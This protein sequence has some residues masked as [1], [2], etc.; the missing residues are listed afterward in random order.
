MHIAV[1]FQ[2]EGDANP[3]AVTEVEG[4]ITDMLL[5]TP[6]DTVSHINLEGKRF[7]GEV[8]RRH[9]DF[10]LEDGLDISG[11]VTVTLTLKRMPERR[12]H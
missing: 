5:P 7:E 10:S 12:V 9:F 4:Q 1:V 2:F 8:L 3:S 6:G 11:V